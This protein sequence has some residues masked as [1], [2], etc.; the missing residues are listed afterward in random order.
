MSLFSQAATMAPWYP[1]PWSNLGEGYMNSGMYDSAIVCLNRALR[2]NPYEYTAY[3][4]LAAAYQYLKQYEKAED[5]F[6]KAMKLRPDNVILLYNMAYIKRLM[7]KHDEYV[8][9]LTRAAEHDDAPLMV[10]KEMLMLLLQQGDIAGSQ[11]CFSRAIDMGLDQETILEL[12][13]KYP[14]LRPK[15]QTDR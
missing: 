7:N 4:N 11:Q 8:T 9:Y 14:Y 2:L 10:V 13:N 5:L 15:N 12:K 1:D 3:G 6:E